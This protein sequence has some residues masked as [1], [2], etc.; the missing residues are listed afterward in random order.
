MTFIRRSLCTLAL[1]VPTFANAALLQVN[2]EAPFGT[3]GTL[4]ALPGSYFVLDTDYTADST[5]T[6]VGAIVE[7]HIIASDPFSGTAILGGNTPADAVDLGTS[8]D[9]A[10]GSTTWSIFVEDPV[11]V[12]KN[13]TMT[14]NFGGID[15][16]TDLLDDPDSYNDSFSSGTVD[17][18][19]PNN[20]F[21]PVH[22]TISTFNVVD[23]SPVPDTP[24]PVPLPPS[25]LLM[26]SSLLLLFGRGKFSFTNA[27]AK[28]DGAAA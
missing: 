3:T 19:D 16:A 7:G 9:A 6:Y 11:V 14:L 25:F 26:A 22:L 4:G 2:F 15:L 23:I 21:S 24:S 8:Y 18:A 12:G 20:P 28:L 17:A 5:G 27:K 10:T 1:A 13:A